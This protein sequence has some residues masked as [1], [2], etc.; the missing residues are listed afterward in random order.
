MDRK[1]LAPP[2]VQGRT[3]ETTR[4]GLQTATHPKSATLTKYIHTSIIANKE[5]ED[6]L[7]PQIRQ[8]NLQGLVSLLFVE[9]KS[10]LLREGKGTDLGIRC[11]RLWSEEK[12]QQEGDVRKTNKTAW[13]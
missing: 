3:G 1:R 9:G 6:H 2:V 12:V 10:W 7:A 11:L 4:S 5:F 8:V 13:L